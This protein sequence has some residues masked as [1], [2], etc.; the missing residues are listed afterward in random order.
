MEHLYHHN[1]RLQKLLTIFFKEETNYFFRPCY[2]KFFQY[3]F[4]MLKNID[5]R[6]LQHTSQKCA[7][8]LHSKK[9]SVHM[10]EYMSAEQTGLINLDSTTIFFPT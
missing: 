6:R 7:Q 4:A 3:F 8:T 5:T 2:M 1:I 9:Y 10:I